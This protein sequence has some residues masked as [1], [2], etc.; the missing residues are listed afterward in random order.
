M[1][2][3]KKISSGQVMVAVAPEVQVVDA[4]AFAETVLSSSRT[5]ATS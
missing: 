2:T 5:P 3:P 1:R 4:L